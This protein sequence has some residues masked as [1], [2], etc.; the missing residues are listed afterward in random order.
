MHIEVK[1]WDKVISVIPAICE[2]GIYCLSIAFNDEEV[3]TYGYKSRTHF[4]EDLHQFK[5][6]GKEVRE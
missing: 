1:D 5:Y 2:D 3:C 6:R 4:I